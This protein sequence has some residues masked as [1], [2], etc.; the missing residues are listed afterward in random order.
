[1]NTDRLTAA[2]TIGYGAG[3]TGLALVNIVVQTWLLYFFAPPVGRTLIPASLV[4]TIWLLGRLL[5]AAADPLV[6]SWSD[7]ARSPAG[8]RIPF[9]LA[10]SIPLAL[11]CLLLFVDGLYSGP[12]LVRALVLAVLLGLYYVLFTV[13]AVPFNS[14]IADLGTDQADR[15][16][17]S[18]SAAVFNLAG[19]AG[20]SVAAGLLI[21][22]FSAERGF[23]AEGFPPAV[24]ILM[25]VAALTFLITPLSLW[26]K[27]RVGREPSP[28]RLF[29]SMR[30]ALG[31]RAFRTYLIGINTFW[32]GFIMINVS[33]PF[34]VTVL[35]G[36]DEG[37]TSIA[38]G[39]SLG[40]ALLCFPLVNLASRRFGNKR[41]VV[42]SAG[43]MAVALALVPFLRPETGPAL[44]LMVMGISGIGLSGLL[45]LPNAM[46]ADL[47]DYRLPDGSKPGEAIYYGL[48]GLVQKA[49]IGVVTAA[50]GILFDLFGNSLER[51]LGIRLTGP[52]GALFAMVAVIVMLRYPDNRNGLT[53]R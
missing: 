47:S 11:V 39:V 31:N 5:D 24:G 37:F 12:L 49:A 21:E 52:I 44:G 51:P 7:R 16:R 25:G 32:G 46:I 13:Y 27:R 22:Q 29:A 38:L 50:G 9:L 26:S 35:M 4:G 43:I 53:P 45:V 48:Q 30:N 34:Y 17:L 6:S 41:T 20:A 3:N 36:R 1:M 40:V 18:T 14:L 19:T 23:D 33:V 42:A 8:R 10:A 15:V 28:M 2:H